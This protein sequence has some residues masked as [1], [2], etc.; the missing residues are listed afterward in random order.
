MQMMPFW[1]KTLGDYR[2]ELGL[3]F[4][5]PDVESAKAGPSNAVSLQRH[6]VGLVAFA[7]RV[8]CTKQHMY[9]EWRERLLTNPSHS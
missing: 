3:I 2:A 1:R 7:K 6:L 9:N 4:P 8:V 5:Y